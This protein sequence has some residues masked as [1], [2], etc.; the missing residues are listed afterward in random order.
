M[1]IVDLVSAWDVPLE[2]V[3]AGDKFC[4]FTDT[5]MDPLVWQS[6][7][8][9][10]KARGAESM[11]CMWPRLRYHNDDPPLMGI[12]AARQADVIMALTSTAL[13]SGTPGLRSLRGAGGGTGNKTIWLM[14]QLTAEIM[15]RG[16]GSVTKDELLEICDI[17]RRVG[18][19]YDK[20]KRVRVM[21]QHGMDISVEIGEYPPGALA[22]RWG[23][24]P[25]QRS[26]EGKIGF[27]TWPYG[28][29]HFEPKPGSANG[30]VVWDTT[31]HHPEGLWREPVILTVKDGRVTSVDGGAEAAEVRWYLETFGDE[32][33]YNLGGEI[34]LGTNKKCP[35]YTGEMRSEKKRYGAMHFGIG[36]GADLSLNNSVLRM[37]GIISRVT[38]IVDDDIV[39]C[40]DGQILV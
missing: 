24:V 39:V 16:G 4:I 40:Q 10:L 14:E 26:P 36:H 34:S 30:T 22:N 17:N 32:N 18:A 2:N 6:A 7:M 33:S 35:P 37:E 28:E 38:I 15:L 21:S 19:V 29:V 11:L 31:A 3:G 20:G 25:F 9:A 23:K 1:R 5:A 13:N 27:G 8:A 12:E